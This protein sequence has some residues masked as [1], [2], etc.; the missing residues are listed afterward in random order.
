[1]ADGRERK[2]PESGRGVVRRGDP[3]GP[4]PRVGGPRTG[5]VDARISVVAALCGDVRHLIK[6]RALRFSDGADHAGGLHL[7]IGFGFDIVFRQ[8]GSFIIAIGGQGQQ[9]ERVRRWQVRLRMG[10]F[11]DRCAMDVEGSRKGFNR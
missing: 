1:M 5:C 6:Q 9:I 11:A 2:G 10:R 7:G 4:Q 3:R 8:I